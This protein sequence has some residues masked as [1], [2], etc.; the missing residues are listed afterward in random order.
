[1]TAVV[2]CIDQDD[3]GEDDMSNVYISRQGE[4]GREEKAEN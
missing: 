3:A 2:N 1:M 4:L